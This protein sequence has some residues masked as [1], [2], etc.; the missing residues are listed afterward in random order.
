MINIVKVALSRPLTFIVMAIVILIA[1]IGAALKTPVDIFPDIRVPVIAVAWQYAGL[2][3]EEMSGR[4]IT[5]YERVLTTTVNDIEH[6]ESQ[7][8]QGIGIV[9]IF[10]QPGAD[11]RTATAQVTAVSQSVLRQLPAGC[12]AAADPELQRVHRADHPAGAL[13]QRPERAAIVRSRAEPDPHPA[14]HRSRRRHSLSVGR[15]DRVRCRSTSILPRCRRAGF[16]RR[17]SARHRRAEPDQSGRLREDRH[18]SI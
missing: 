11:V 15:Q 9:K 4:I 13:R 12:H 7:S 1:G 16:P 17:M 3:P 6:I 8:M 14:R 10:L 5:P 2:P 18:L